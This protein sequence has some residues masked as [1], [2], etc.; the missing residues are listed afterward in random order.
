MPPE[1]SVEVLFVDLLNKCQRAISTSLADT[2]AETPLL[3]SVV[4]FEG[5]FF[6]I[7]VVDVGNL[8]F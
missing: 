4:N 8:E 2:E 5:A 3:D 6:R 1:Q 7:L